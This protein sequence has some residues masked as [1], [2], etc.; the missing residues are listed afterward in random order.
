[1][2]FRWILETVF[3]VHYIK[4]NNSIALYNQW[5]FRTVPKVQRGRKEINF[6]KGKRR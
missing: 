5:T 1:M 6:E 2:N 3:K 4:K